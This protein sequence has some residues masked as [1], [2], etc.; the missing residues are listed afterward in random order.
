MDLSKLM[1]QA[2]KLQAAQADLATKTVEVKDP[3]G[4]VTVVA[5]AGGELQSLAVDPAIV[6]S[7]DTDFLTDLILTTANRALT[8]AREIAAKDLAENFKIPG[9][10]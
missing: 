1:E 4:K 9:M 7:D 10:G 5:T 6:S 2:Q 8:D 3:S